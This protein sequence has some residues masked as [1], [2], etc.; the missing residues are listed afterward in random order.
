MIKK[1]LT[2]RVKA[3]CQKKWNASHFLTWYCSVSTLVTFDAHLSLSDVLWPCLHVSRFVCIRRHFI[4][5]TKIYAS[6]RM[7]ICSVFD[8]PHVSESDPNSILKCS[9]R[10]LSMRWWINWDDYQDNVRSKWMGDFRT[11]TTSFSKVCGYR[12]PHVTAFVAFSKSLNSGERFQKFSGAVCVLA[13]YV[14]TRNKM[15]ADTNESGHVWTGP[16]TLIV[17]YFRV[18]IPFCPVHLSH[19]RVLY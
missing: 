1:K 8:R 16:Q 12:R 11:F 14:W 13:G 7:R 17:F 10:L 18:F 4:A 19:W 6:T 15:F 9:N 2:S 5:V 3:L